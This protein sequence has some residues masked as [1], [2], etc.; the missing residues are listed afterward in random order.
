M[1]RGQNIAMTTTS[2]DQNAGQIQ[3]QAT[4]TTT[5]AKLSTYRI[6]YSTGNDYRYHLFHSLLDAVVISQRYS[7]ANGLIILSLG[8]IL[9]CVTKLIIPCST[10]LLSI[11]QMSIYNEP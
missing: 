1:G 8:Y 2:C 4:G 7:F 6:E 10:R 9:H 5:S 11:T 3:Q